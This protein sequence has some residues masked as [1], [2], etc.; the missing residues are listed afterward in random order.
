[1]HQSINETEQNKKYVLLLKPDADGDLKPTEVGPTLL[2]DM[3]ILETVGLEHVLHLNE[4]FLLPNEYL[5]V[6]MLD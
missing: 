5:S 6:F 4:L 1:M 2:D 3:N